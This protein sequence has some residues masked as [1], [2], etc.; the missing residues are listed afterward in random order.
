MVGGA[1][2]FAA[3]S[4]LAAV[5]CVA[6]GSLNPVKIGAVRAVFAPLAPGALV[7]SV[8]SPSG[9]SDQPWGD[10]ETI[11]GARAR[12]QHAR[13]TADADVGVGIEG[14]VVDGPEGLRTCAWA[15]VVS[16][17]GVTGIGGSLA[18]ALPPFVATLVREGVELGAAMDRAS[19][20]V[21]T[22]RGHGAVGIL[23]AGLIDRQRAYEVLVTYAL[24]PFLAAEYWR[25]PAS[26]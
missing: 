3:A 1:D 15:V 18:L 2:P 13:Q 5:R 11:R 4:G 26:A 19:G 24:A 20:M 9:V 10:D 16:R 17:D 23:T 8:G 21:D 22:K 14:G 25:A 7:E 12:A 6:V